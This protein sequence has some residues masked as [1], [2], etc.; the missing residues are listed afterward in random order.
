MSLPSAGPGLRR[1]THR[2]P[3]PF[4]GETQRLLLDLLIAPKPD[5]DAFS[6]WAGHVDIQRLD[7]GTAGLLPALYLRLS[8]SGIE[9]PWMAIMRGW[10]RRTLYRNRLLV[11]RTLEQMDLLR[12]AGIDCLVLNGMAVSSLYYRDFGVRPIASAGLLIG[13]SIDRGTI[14]AILTRAS[15]M[16]LTGRALHADTYADADDFQFDLHWH[17]SP[18]LAYA[19]SSRG[20]WQ[21]AQPIALEERAYRTLGA[22]D[23][24]VHGLIDGLRPREVSLPHWILDIAT[25]SAAAPAFDWERLTSVCQEM[26]VG[27]LA[28]GGLAFLS[29]AGYAPKD[30]GR[31]AEVLARTR[32]PWSDRLL[33]DGILRQRGLIF[34]CLRPWLIYSRLARLEYRRRGPA[35]FIR[36]LARLWGL[37]GG[38]KVPRAAV[39]RIAARL[40]TSMWAS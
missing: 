2:M 18:E 26:A 37:P 16:R 3:T 13:E 4:P 14:A 32:E 36:F 33:F 5:P 8:Q 31:A 17:L 38:R 9:H 39:G 35:D 29:S 20:L 10:Y 7:E 11:H 28:S 30:A 6:R 15:G 19:G 34:S 1:P 27:R 23:H 12:S 24:V 22:E 40:R 25:V 21:R